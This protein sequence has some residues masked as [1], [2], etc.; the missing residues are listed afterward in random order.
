MRRVSVRRGVALLALIAVCLV[1]V[2]AFADAAKIGMPPGAP[3]TSQ[4][5]SAEAE[6]RMPPGFWDAAFL[7]LLEAMA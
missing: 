7:V 4:P 1:P 6:I 2:A 5:P 3:A